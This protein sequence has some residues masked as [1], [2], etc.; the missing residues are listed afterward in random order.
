MVVDTPTKGGCDWSWENLASCS[1]YDTSTKQWEA[2]HKQS[3]EPE[4][5]V[6]AIHFGSARRDETRRRQLHFIF[7]QPFS[8]YATISATK[9]K[10]PHRG[11]SAILGH[12]IGQANGLDHANIRKFVKKNSQIL[13]K[14]TP[15]LTSSLSFFLKKIKSLPSAKLIC[16]LISSLM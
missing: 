5:I 10:C 16:I 8:V 3:W 4:T 13:D 12:R 9:K 7:T 15:S 2:N 1:S 6:S 14:S 11:Q